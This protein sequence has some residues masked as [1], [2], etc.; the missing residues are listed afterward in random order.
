MNRLAPVV[1]TFFVLLASTAYAES[2][3]W[4]FRPSNFSHDPMTGA[5]VAQ[6][7]RKP[8]VEPLPDVRAVTSR[9]NRKRTNLRGADGSL[10]SYYEVQAWGNGRGGIDAEWERFNNVWQ[11][12]Y[13]TGSQS[14]GGFGNGFGNGYGNGY[15][16]GSGYPQYG[17]Y[18]GYGSPG[19]GSPGYR[20]PGP[21]HPGPG[22]APPI[23]RPGAPDY[24]NRQPHGGGHHGHGTPRARDE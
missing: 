2:A 18:P 20:Y 6:Y 21:G 7:V 17:G 15:G 19:Y 14:Q 5:R 24:G 9:Y 13:L 16:G 10:D 11:D 3:S 8:P 12:S 22:F 4:M 1:A 23:Y